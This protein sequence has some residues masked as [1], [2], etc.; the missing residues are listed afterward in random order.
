MAKLGVAF[1]EFAYWVMAFAYTLGF[2]L[3]G[4]GVNNVPKTGPVLFIANHQSFLDPVAIGLPIRRHIFYLARKTLF[5]QPAFGR[6]LRAVNC[7]PIDQEGVGKEG[8]RKI[9][10]KL[11]DG[12]AVLVFPEGERSWDGQMNELRPGI[13]LLLKRVQVPVV[14]VGIAG[15][16]EA[17]PRTKKWP[18]F[19]PLWRPQFGCPIAVSIGPPR[20]PKS[21]AHLS[22]E[23]LLT[24]LHRDIEVEWRHAQRMLAHR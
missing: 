13:V 11:E 7:V 17:W 23:E 12:A 19:G 3:R 24:T 14:P 1:Y 10:E 8:I 5:A 20:D 15:A 22:R 2:R 18:R 9:I 4:R 16:F 6:L 21:Y